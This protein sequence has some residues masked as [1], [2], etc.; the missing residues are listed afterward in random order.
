MAAFLAHVCP[1][2]SSL[3]ASPPLSR[4]LTDRLGYGPVSI[5]STASAQMFG[6]DAP[7]LP[8]DEAR[9]YTRDRIELYYLAHAGKPLNKVPCFRGC[10]RG[11]GAGPRTGTPPAAP[12]L[13]RPRGRVSLRA[14][15]ALCDRRAVPIRRP[16]PGMPSPPDRAPKP[17]H[18]RGHDDSTALLP[19]PSRL[20][21]LTGLNPVP[22][23]TFPPHPMTP[24]LT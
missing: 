11:P 8:W 19:N 2:W 5:P 20:A 7:P 15:R 21:L 10:V 13:R 12:D 22:H 16:K 9:E 24:K 1:C 3:I 23:P 18:P 17:Q 4:A 6:P 14:Q